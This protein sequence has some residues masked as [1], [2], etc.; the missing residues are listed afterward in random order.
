VILALFGPGGR[1]ND[2]SARVTVQ[3]TTADGAPVG[4][5]VAAVAVRPPGLD[6]VSWVATLDIPSPRA[7]RLNVTAQAGALPL[8]GSTGL[9]TALE[10]GATPALGSPAPSIHTPTLDDVGGDARAVTTDPIPDRRLSARSTTDALSDHVP[11]VL[12]LD[13]TR[14]RVT[15]ACGRALVMARYLLDRW[16]QVTFIHHEPFRYSI[17]TDTPVLDGTLVDPPLTDVA[18]AWGLGSAPW[19]AVSM[20]WIFIVD[21]DGIVRA[22]YQ[23]IVGSEDVDV[24]VSL[25]AQ[26]G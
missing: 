24:I 13:S 23:G 25:I 4:G 18:A 10:Q 5:T 1:L 21:G 16:P 14:F 2:T 17:V 15:P 20:P 26:G 3:L 12:V 11:F 9:V 7:W 19:D 8:T 6:D 22:K